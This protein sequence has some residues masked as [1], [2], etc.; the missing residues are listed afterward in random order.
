M[1]VVDYFLDD[2]LEDRLDS[3]SRIMLTKVNSEP[4]R[5][6]RVQALTICAGGRN[7]LSFQDF[8]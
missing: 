4:E 3:E 2:V 7:V 6:F 8:N 5:D 1:K